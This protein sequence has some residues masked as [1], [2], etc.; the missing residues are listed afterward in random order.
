MI[1]FII[2]DRIKNRRSYWKALVDVAL[3]VLRSIT[4]ISSKAEKAGDGACQPE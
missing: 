2:D 1:C 3:I 4:S